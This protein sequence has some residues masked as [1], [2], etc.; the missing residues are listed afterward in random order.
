VGVDTVPGIPDFRVE[1][2]NNIDKQTFGQGGCVVATAGAI[3]AGDYCAIQCITDVEL[4][5]LAAPKLTG[6]ITGIPLPAGTV[7]FTEFTSGTVTS[8]TAIAYRSVK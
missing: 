8:G 7:I 5:A 2:T 6:T 3:A 1:M 4:T